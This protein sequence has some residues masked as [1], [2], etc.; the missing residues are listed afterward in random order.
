MT[1]HYTRV[2]P[3]LQGLPSVLRTLL[4]YISGCADKN[5]RAWIFKIY[6]NGNLVSQHIAS[7]GTCTSHTVSNAL[8]AQLPTAVAVFPCVCARVHRRDVGSCGEII[9]ESA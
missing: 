8:L 1:E 5:V 2:S 6:P 9:V 7:Q 4:F 3:E